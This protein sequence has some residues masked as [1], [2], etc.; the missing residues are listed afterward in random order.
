MT[1]IPKHSGSETDL[2][3]DWIPFKYED[4]K[5]IYRIRETTGIRAI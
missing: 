2:V 5:R 1:T 4:L 3:L